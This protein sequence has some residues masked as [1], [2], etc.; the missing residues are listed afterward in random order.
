MAAEE[1][2]RG[3]FRAETYREFNRRIDKLKSDVDAL[4]TDGG[5]FAGY[6]AARG[7]TT[8]LYRLGLNGRLAFI[9]DDSPAK[10]NLF[11]PGDH[12]PILPSEALYSQKPD[13]VFILAWVH[14]KAIVKAHQRYLDGGG[15]FVVAHPGLDVISSVRS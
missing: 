10:Q 8:L 6:G 7:G 9:A 14:W 1:E 11:S 13:Y 3:F 5:K 12:A 2:R 4:L 15:R